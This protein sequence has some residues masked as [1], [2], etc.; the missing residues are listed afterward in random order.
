[1]KFLF[2][3]SFALLVSKY[4]NQLLEDNILPLK[5][6]FNILLNLILCLIIFRCKHFH[7]RSWKRWQTILSCLKTQWYFRSLPNHFGKKK[8]GKLISTYSHLHLKPHIEVFFTLS[9]AS[10]ACSHCSSFY[11]DIVYPNEY[12][13]DLRHKGTLSSYLSSITTLI[14]T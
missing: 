6:C 4:H 10:L 1:M 2:Q 7:G 5:Y 13:D 11:K 12:V 8:G 9:C 14:Y 3:S